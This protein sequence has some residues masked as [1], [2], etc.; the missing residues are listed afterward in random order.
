MCAKLRLVLLAP[1]FGSVWSCSPPGARKEAVRIG[2]QGG[3]VRQRAALPQ[4]PRVLLRELLPRRH[5]PPATISVQPPSGHARHAMLGFAP[6]TRGLHCSTAAERE[7]NNTVC[8]FRSNT[9]VPSVPEPGTAPL[10]SL[11]SRHSVLNRDA[12]SNGVYVHLLS[13][14]EIDSECNPLPS[15]PSLPAP[16][17]V[18]PSPHALLSCAKLGCACC[19]KASARRWPAVVGGLPR[20]MSTGEGLGVHL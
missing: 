9:G 6:F 1:P 12:L 8:A 20:F 11:R 4:P 13:A 16:C 17:R 19:K 18:A 7:D 3:G 15:P 2:A 14:S 5:A 10:S